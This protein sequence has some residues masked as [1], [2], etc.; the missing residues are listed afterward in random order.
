MAQPAQLT[1]VIETGRG[2]IRARLFWDKTPLTVANFVNLALRG[3][4]SGLTF[5][6]VEPEFVIQGGCPR[7]D[8]TGGPG[9][10]FEDEIVK[11]LRHDKAGILSMANAGPGTN[12]SQFFV[13]HVAAPWLDRK[14]TVFGKTLGQKDLEVVNSVAAGDKILKIAI[15][16]DTAPLLAKTRTRLDGWNRALDENFPH[17]GPAAGHIAD[18]LP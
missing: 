5:H 2:T 9:Y 14:H 11:D 15:E 3:F 18:R 7:G 8:G 4:Y 1:A 6:R 17:L 12:G 13:T 16:G 10:R